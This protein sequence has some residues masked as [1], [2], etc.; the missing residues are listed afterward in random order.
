[1]PARLRYQRPNSVIGMYD[2]IW[3]VR[4]QAAAALAAMPYAARPMRPPS[5]NTPANPGVEGTETKAT[6]T[7]CAN[8]AAEKGALMCR[9]RKASQKAN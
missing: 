1:M 9:A 5:S 4:L 8:S 3:K 7:P 2:T 6:I